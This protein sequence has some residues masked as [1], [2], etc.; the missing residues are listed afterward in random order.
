MAIARSLRGDPKS[1]P[2]DLHAL[3]E[4]LRELVVETQ[5]AVDEDAHVFLER[6]VGTSKLG[7]AAKAIIGFAT[8]KDPS[9][10]RDIQRHVLEQRI[11]RVERWMARK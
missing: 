7:K 8:E 9:R 11:A 10:L 3:V 6:L 4:L 1:M 5:T 2:K